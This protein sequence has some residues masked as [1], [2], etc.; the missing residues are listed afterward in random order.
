MWVDR[1]V[2]DRAF[3][4]ALADADSLF[5][6][7]NCQIVKD[8]RK[9]KVAW[10]TT[11]IAGNRRT[12]YVK[13]YNSFSLRF[14]LL[15]PF[16]RSGA[17]RAL[18]G[19]AILQ[20][21]RIGSAR[22][23]A[24]VEIRRC[25]ILFNSFFISEEIAGGQTVDAYWIKNLKGRADPDGFRSRRQFIQQLAELFRSLHAERI[26]HNDLKDANILAVRLDSG[27]GCTLSL[28]D[29]EGVRHCH[30]LSERR[31]LKNMVQLYRTLG[32]YLSRSHQLFFLK[33]YLGTSFLD[34]RRK[35]EWIVGVL[36]RA[37]LID[38]AKSQSRIGMSL[39]LG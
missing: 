25:G 36:H 26:Y 22:P 27:V 10:L 21:A 35:R 28:L 4:D 7:G 2:A 16:F 32:K 19:A 3:I 8:Q 23:V 15:S 6:T 20:R 13:Q 12:L 1:E 24:G 5:K 9:I 31:R 14:K 17:L 29:L 38:R 33:S 30:R 34:P 11:T 37:R 18:E 39:R